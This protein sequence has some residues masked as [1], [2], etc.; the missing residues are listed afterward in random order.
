MSY[1]LGQAPSPEVEIEVEDPVRVNVGIPGVSAMIPLTSR[2][3]VWLSVGL[4]AL[5]L[6]GGAVL[7]ASLLHTLNK[8][9][10]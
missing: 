4:S 2:R 8:K 7:L 3:R 9:G 1:L 5:V 10:R 6:G